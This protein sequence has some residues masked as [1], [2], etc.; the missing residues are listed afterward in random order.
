MPATRTGLE[1]IEPVY[2]CLPGWRT[3]T[4]GVSQFEDLPQPA[5][6]YLTYLENRTGVEVGCISTGPERNQTIVRRTSRF[7]QLFS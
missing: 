2:E 6:D 4:V 3:S 7:A 1:N 5:R